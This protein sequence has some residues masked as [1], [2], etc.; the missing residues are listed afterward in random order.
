MRETPAPLRAHG[1]SLPLALVLEAMEEAEGNCA[2]AFA[3]AQRWVE[4][5]AFAPLLSARVCMH[6][7]MRATPAPLRLSLPGTV[8]GAW[9]PAGLR[10]Q[11]WGTLQVLI[12]LSFNV[13][14]SLALSYPRR[15]S[16]ASPELL[17][18]DTVERWPTGVRGPRIPGDQPTKAPGRPGCL[19]AGQRQPRV[20]GCVSLG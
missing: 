16:Q 19:S 1:L 5:S 10:V 17:C 7:E 20:L 14:L 15:S 9:Q 4:V 2:V 3:E 13:Q 6:R 11:F 12:L 18:Q 8:T